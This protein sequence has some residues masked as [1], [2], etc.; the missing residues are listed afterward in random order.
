MSSLGRSRNNFNKKTRGGE[1]VWWHFSAGVPGENKNPL[2]LRGKE[3]VSF[4]RLL[5]RKNPHGRE[6]GSIILLTIVDIS[7][8]LN[9]L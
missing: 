4:L 3:W 1:K 5:R 8:F 6:T 7:S 9:G 2:V